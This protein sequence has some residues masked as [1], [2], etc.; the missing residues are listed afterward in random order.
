MV[1]AERQMSGHV[2][3]A[4]R[5]AVDNLFF[6]FEKGSSGWQQ[7]MSYFY[8]RLFSQSQLTSSAG[9][10]LHEICSA[11]LQLLRLWSTGGCCTYFNARS[12]NSGIAWSGF[13]GPISAKRSARDWIC[14]WNQGHIGMS[15][16]FT[17]VSWLFH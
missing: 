1:N 9:L 8:M 12:R 2:T 5:D 16:R 7:T 15:P 17:F 3:A 11:Y 6:F 10:T 13:T 4:Y 14:G